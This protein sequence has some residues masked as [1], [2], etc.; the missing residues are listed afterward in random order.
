[1][2]VC[3]VPKVRK[4]KRASRREE[5]TEKG[6]VISSSSGATILLGYWLSKLTKKKDF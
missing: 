1:M 2:M 3:I 4:Q 5:G 6:C